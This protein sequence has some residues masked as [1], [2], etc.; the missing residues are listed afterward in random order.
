[1]ASRVLRLSSSDVPGGSAVVLAAKS[2]ETSTSGD[3]NRHLHR[4]LVG[5]RTRTVFVNFAQKKKVEIISD[6][7]QRAIVNINN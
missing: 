6:C 4:W 7:R 2:R 1:M 5:F 3:V